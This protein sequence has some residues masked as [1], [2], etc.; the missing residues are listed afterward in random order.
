IP[1]LCQKF[2]QPAVA[3]TD[4]NNLFGALEIAMLCA[5]SGIQ[6][7]TGCE[8]NIKIN[9]ITGPLVLLVASKEGYKNLLDLVSFLY[10]N[11]T[12]NHDSLCVPFDY[13]KDRTKGLIA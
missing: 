7:I 1:K 4:T 5:S 3:I 6:P 13:L 8:L 11:P 10:L 2:D 12:P 9:N